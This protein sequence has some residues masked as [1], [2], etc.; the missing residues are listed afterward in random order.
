MSDNL[1][2]LSDPPPPVPVRS[3]PCQEKQDPFL[4]IPHQRHGPED[5]PEESVLEGRLPSPLSFFRDE[6][7]RDLRAMGVSIPLGREDRVLGFLAHRLESAPYSESRE[8]T[9][10]RDLV[11]WQGPNVDFSGSGPASSD[12]GAFSGLGSGDSGSRGVPRN[13]LFDFPFKGQTSQVQ[14]EY[15]VSNPDSHV[16]ASVSEFCR[17]Y[18]YVISLFPEAQ[19]S[20][21]LKAPPRCIYEACVR[22][23]N[24][25][26]SR[27]IGSSSSEGSLRLFPI[28]RIG[29]LKL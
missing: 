14:G 27:S 7:F 13:V 25:L 29:L 3:L 9:V 8:G 11:E 1:H 12:A 26:H 24:L 21:P 4:R 5:E 19:S 16:P 22:V 17:L 15:E 2:S 10:A 20:T 23:T 28:Q 18:E 6:C